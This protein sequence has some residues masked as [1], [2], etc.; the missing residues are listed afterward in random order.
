MKP[1]EIFTIISSILFLAGCSVSVSPDGTRNFALDMEN[2]AKAYVTYS[3][4]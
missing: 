1:T 3:S 4:K 2:A